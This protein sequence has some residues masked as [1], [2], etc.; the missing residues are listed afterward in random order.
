[1][2]GPMA[3][4]WYLPTLWLLEHGTPTNRTGWL[5]EPDSVTHLLRAAR[6]VWERSHFAAILGVRGHDN[7]SSQNMEEVRWETPLQTAMREFR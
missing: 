6:R 7:F 5:R 1:M 4:L 2:C 3:G